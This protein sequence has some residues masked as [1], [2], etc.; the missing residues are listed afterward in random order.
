MKRCSG[1]SDRMSIVSTKIQIAPLDMRSPWWDKSPGTDADFQA[2][3]DPGWVM[4]EILIRWY[5]GMS[6]LTRAR[7]LVYGPIETLSALDL[8]ANWNFAVID[9]DAA[10][11][12]W[13]KLPEV[14]GTEEFYGFWRKFEGYRPYRNSIVHILLNSTRRVTVTESP[15]GVESECQVIPKTH[16]GHEA[17]SSSR[18]PYP[19]ISQGFFRGR[20]AFA[21]AVSICPLA[22]L[23]FE[24]WDDCLSQHPE[25][26]LAHESLKTQVERNYDFDA[27]FYVHV[28]K[29]RDPQDS[30]EYC[31]GWDRRHKLAPEV[32]IGS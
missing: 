14:E 12:A 26:A 32:Y 15:L 3:D 7:M 20:V 6:H 2:A 9:F 8:D 1:L 23:M 19:G 24:F 10:V 29:H 27:Q 13:G 30:C 16:S 21:D 31:F 17:S 5:R 25:F 22:H 28:L 18:F 4:G 11:E